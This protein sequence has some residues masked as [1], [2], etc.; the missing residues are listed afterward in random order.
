MSQLNGLSVL[1]VEVEIHLTFLR[2]IFSLCREGLGAAMPRWVASLPRSRASPASRWRALPDPRAGR[3]AEPCD[4]P[5]ESASGATMRYLPRY[6]PLY[7][8]GAGKLDL[9]RSV[10][11]SDT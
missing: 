8:Q 11:S 2:V 7:R 5:P 10:S 3:R 4:W 9:N 6:V 1:V